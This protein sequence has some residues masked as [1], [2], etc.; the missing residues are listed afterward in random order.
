MEIGGSKI[1]EIKISKNWLFKYEITTFSEHQKFDFRISLNR[2]VDCNRY[3][4][5]ISVCKLQSAFC[6]FFRVDKHIRQSSTGRF[7]SCVPFQTFSYWLAVQHY[8]PASKG[9][10]SMA[11]DEESRLRSE[12][13][14]QQSQ[15]RHA[16]ELI[17]PKLLEYFYKSLENKSTAAERVPKWT[18]R[19]EDL[20]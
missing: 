2:V 6:G 5:H 13:E 3:S 8:I 11:S 19:V 10:N 12:V 16:G 7:P 14:Q 9:D 1:A 4:P 15:L 18:K 17:D 20:K